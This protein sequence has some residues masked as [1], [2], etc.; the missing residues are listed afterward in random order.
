MEGLMLG[1]AGAALAAALA[2][3]GSAVGTGIAGQAGSGVVAEDPEKFGRLLLLQALPGTQGIYGIVGLFLAIGKLGDLGMSA[4]TVGPPDGGIKMDARDL[5]SYGEPTDTI[6]QKASNYVWDFHV[7]LA[8]EL[9]KSHPDKHL[10][11]VSGAGA[12]EVPTNIEEFPDNILVPPRWGSSSHRVLHSMDS[13]A[14][15]GHQKWLDT[16]E[17]IR[18]APSWDH[19]LNYRTPTHP[20]QGLWS[21]E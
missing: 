11:Y 15:A 16:M 10:L 7:Y 1:I 3:T 20:R 13:A 21:T 19:W 18:K 17:A 5:D 2:G 9:K 6:D 14:M 12:R 8:K 4:M